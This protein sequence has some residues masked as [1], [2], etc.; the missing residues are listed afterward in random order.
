MEKRGDHYFVDL[1]QL[2]YNEQVEK[3]GYN[4]VI[5]TLEL[6][7][8][9]AGWYPKDFINKGLNSIF[10]D[11]YLE[12]VKKKVV[13]PEEKQYKY[14]KSKDKEKFVKNYEIFMALVEEDQD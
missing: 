5:F 1:F 9:I 11:N 2:S 13:F 8:S 6:V 12:L 10:Q 7:R 3:Y 4:Y 14:I